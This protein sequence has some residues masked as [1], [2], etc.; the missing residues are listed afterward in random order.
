MFRLSFATTA[1]T[2]RGSVASLYLSELDGHPF[3]PQHRVNPVDAGS[4]AREERPRC[5]NDPRRKVGRRSI[6]RAAYPARHHIEA[7]VALETRQDSHHILPGR[8]ACLFVLTHPM[9]GSWSGHARGP[10][11]RKGLAPLTRCLVTYGSLSR[12]D[13]FLAYGSLSG[14]PDP[15]RCS[16][17]GLDRKGHGPHAGARAVVREGKNLWMVLWAVIDGSPAR[18]YIDA[19]ASFVEDLMAG[20]KAETALWLNYKFTVFG[21]DDVRWHEVGGLYVFAELERDERGWLQ[22]HPWYIGRAGDFSDRLPSHER[23]SEAV[24]LGATHIHAMVETN[25]LRRKV[26]EEEL[27]EYYRPAMNIL[28]T[29]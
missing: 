26:I 16:A 11:T 18:S 14:S 15:S 5:L 4:F 27:I 13:V 20:E 23:W 3:R 1:S 17:I 10:E 19:R 6:L 28:L 7:A 12:C 2:G 25:A 8:G 24:L 21:P 9:W 29:E 22:W